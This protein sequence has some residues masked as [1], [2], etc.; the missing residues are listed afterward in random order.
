MLFLLLAAQVAAQQPLN[1]TCFGGGVA[2]KPAVATVNSYGS[3]SGNVGTTP[4]YGNAS[5]SSTI[6]GQRQQGFDDQVDVRLFGGDDRIRLP[7]TILPP[8]HGG[9]DGWFKLKDVVADGRSIHAKAAINF[10]NSPKVYIDRVTGSISISGKAGDYTG[11]CQ[12]VPADA[13]AKF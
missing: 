8:V 10:I 4:V 12:A 11:Q 5:G 9:A 1:L 3:F 6:V 2:N 13:P 7:R